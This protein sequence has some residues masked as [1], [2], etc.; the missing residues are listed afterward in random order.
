MYSAKSIA[1]ALKA[2]NKLLFEGIDELGC[3]SPVP[4][5]NCLGVPKK[6]NSCLRQ[7]C[8]QRVTIYDSYRKLAILNFKFMVSLQNQDGF[9]RKDDSTLLLLIKREDLDETLLRPIR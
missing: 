9:I 5:E 7:L 6:C 8:K 3:P 2:N 4:H 1:N